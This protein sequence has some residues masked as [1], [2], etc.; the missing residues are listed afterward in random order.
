[1][2][3]I[4]NVFLVAGFTLILSGCAAV[5][6][7]GGAAGGYAT[8]KHKSSISQYTDDSYITSKVKAKFLADVDLKSYNISVAT[9]KGIVTL[10]GSVPTGKMRKQAIDIVRHTDGVRAVNVTNLKVVP[11]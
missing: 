1:M 7:G 2:K 4:L 3:Q 6:V 10:T 11:Q 5:L 8:A 9:D